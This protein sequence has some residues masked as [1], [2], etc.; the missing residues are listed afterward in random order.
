[1][2]GFDRRRQEDASMP[3][4]PIERRTDPG[5]RE[6]VHRAAE[7]FVIVAPDRTVRIM[8][9]AAERMLGVDRSASRRST[10]RSRATN[11]PTVRER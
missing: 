2:P 4:T 10:A 1:M 11:R 6:L 5:L 8:N 3:D 9:E 7:G